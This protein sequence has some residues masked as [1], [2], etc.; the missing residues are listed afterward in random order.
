MLNDIAKDTKLFICPEAANRWGYTWNGSS[1]RFYNTDNTGLWIIGSTGKMGGRGV[2]CALRLGTRWIG[3]NGQ[4][5]PDGSKD[6][7]H[8]YW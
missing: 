8:H 3:M 6:S 2:V 5:G 7:A 4:V 1:Y